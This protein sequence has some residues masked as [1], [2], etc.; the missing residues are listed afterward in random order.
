MVVIRAPGSSGSQ[1]WLV[2]VTSTASAG[3]RA[4]TEVTLKSVAGTPEGHGDGQ[5]SWAILGEL[6]NPSEPLVP[7]L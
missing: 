4:E 3:S 5:Q 6:L 7:L 2:N 1:G